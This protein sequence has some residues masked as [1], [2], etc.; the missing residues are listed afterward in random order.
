[1]TLRAILLLL[2]LPIVADDSVTGTYDLPTNTIVIRQDTVA[3]ALHIPA[4]QITAGLRG[5]YS[6]IRDHAGYERSWALLLDAGGSGID[7]TLPIHTTYWRVPLA[8]P[9]TCTAG[10]T[11]DLW[12]ARITVRSIT[13]PHIGSYPC[14]AA[15][16][17]AVVW[18][19]VPI[20]GKAIKCD[21]VMEAWRKRRAVRP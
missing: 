19:A 14:S 21:E 4:E 9:P 17:C 12:P 5:A 13:D 2:A 11:F 10:S 16:R 15:S 3:A 6:I 18:D 1:M 8:P 20:G 7:G